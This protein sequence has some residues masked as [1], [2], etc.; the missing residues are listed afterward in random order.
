MQEAVI[1]SAVRTPIGTFSGAFADVPATQLG[2]IVIKEAITRA[3]IDPAQV[4]EVVMGNVLQ[5]GLG[6]NPTRQAALAAGLPVETPATTVNKVCGSSLK[7]VAMAAAAVMLGDADVVVAGGMENMTRAPFL[8]P[9]GRTGHKMG[10]TQLLD[11][12][13]S[14][15]LW[16][17]LED[18][19]MGITAEN[20]NAQYEITRVEQD[21]FAYNSQQRAAKAI[22]NGVFKDEIVPVE[23]PGRK[24][25]VKIVDTDEHPRAD[26]TVETLG[27]LRPAFKPEGSV[28][29]GNASG[30]N[31]G[32]AAVVVMS[33]DKATELGVKPLA[34]IKGYASAG[35]EP[36]VMGI[37]PVPAV[38]KVLDRT[39]LQTKDI[40]VFELNEAFAAQSVAVLRDLGLDPQNVNPNGGAIALGHPLGASG[41]RIL[42]TLL[43]EMQRRGS[44]RG[45][46]TLCIGGGQGIAMV[47][48]NGK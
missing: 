18:C 17:A 11:S 34:T 15:G 41:S 20:I 42:T 23:V 12:M 19:H 22:A 8:Y 46:A 10:H 48:E 1:A 32:A 2:A 21:E 44:H 45:L 43:Y 7:S 39:G 24:G 16:C 13:I 26:T 9:E 35:V 28:T 6:M 31:D 36:R 27:K 30:I 3:G 14:E 47:V 38:K 5:A 4:D 29:A 33:A 40:D 25:E 37:G